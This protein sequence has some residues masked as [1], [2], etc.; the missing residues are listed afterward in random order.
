MEEIVCFMGLDMTAWKAGFLTQQEVFEW[1]AKS[2]LFDHRRFTAHAERKGK[3]RGMYLAWLE[4]AQGQSESSGEVEER[5]ARRP[6]ILPE[7]LV[8]FNKKEE[9]EGVIGERTLRIL[10][11]ETFSGRRVRELTG[12]VPE[13]WKTVKNVTDATRAKAYLKLAD[14]SEERPAWMANFGADEGV[15]RLLKSQGVEAL[16]ALVKSAWMDVQAVDVATRADVGLV[17]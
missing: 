6:S 9:Y 4:W 10:M 14:T 1:A 13:D 16:E 12:A 17:V 2:Y 15:A 8:F 5:P 3:P 7:A 11:R